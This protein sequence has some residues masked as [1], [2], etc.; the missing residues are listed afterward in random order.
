MNE[1]DEQWLIRRVF[2]RSIDPDAVALWT[3]GL[4]ILFCFGITFIMIAMVLYRI[5][6]DMRISP[7]L[8]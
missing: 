2:R 7:S 4:M 3:K 6:R 8:P 5:M 1:H